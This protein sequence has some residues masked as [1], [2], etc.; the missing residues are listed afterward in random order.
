[1]LVG[2]RK[3]RA[4][5]DFEA[6]RRLPPLAVA[7]SLE[8]VLGTRLPEIYPDLMEDINRQAVAREDHLPARFSRHIK[9]RVL[10][11]D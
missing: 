8:V 4:V 6:G 11:K 3:S 5:S 2:L 7:L 9:G 10:G 1:M